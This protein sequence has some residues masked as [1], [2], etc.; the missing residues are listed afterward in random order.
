MNTRLNNGNNAGALDALKSYV[1]N[2]DNLRTTTENFDT[3]INGGFPSLYPLPN[4]DR[5]AV[6]SDAAQIATDLN[7]IENNPSGP[8][9]SDPWLPVQA[10][11]GTYTNDFVEAMQ[12][13]VRFYDSYC[14]STAS[15][16]FGRN[17]R[18]GGLR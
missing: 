10:N 2:A 5:A 1:G 18:I 11:A 8:I 7:N 9:V 13:R 4:P 6:V 14:P 12:Y 15:R 16:T 3:T 17:L